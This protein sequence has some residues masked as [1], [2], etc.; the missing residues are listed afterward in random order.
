[1]SIE[2]SKIVNL[3]DAQ[4]LYN[5][6]RGRIKG[7]I[8]DTKGIGDTDFVW[9][10]DKS[11]KENSNLKSAVGTITGNE[12]IEE[13]SENHLYIKNNG[14]TVTIDTPTTTQS[15]VHYMVIECEEGDAFNITASGGDGSRV[16]SFVDV[17]GNNLAMAGKNATYTNRTV[18][19]PADTAYIVV[20]DTTLNGK[21]L[22]NEL[23][24]RV[25]KDTVSK[26]SAFD[27]RF[28]YLFKF[29]NY[30]YEKSGD[31]A[32][33][34]SA[35]D[36][37]QLGIKRD[38]VEFI[39]DGSYINADTEIASIRLSGPVSR[40]TRSSWDIGYF[41]PVIGHEYRLYCIY[42]SGDVS[43][44]ET[45]PSKAPSIGVYKPSASGSYAT[46]IYSDEQ[47]RVYKFTATQTDYNIGMN[48]SLAAQYSFANAK[49][50]LLVQDMTENGIIK[51]L[52]ELEYL[53]KI[54]HVQ[55]DIAKGYWRK[56]GDINPDTTGIC[57]SALIQSTPGDTIKVMINDPKFVYSVMQGDTATSLKFSDR[58]VKYAEFTITGNYWGIIFYK[59][60]D[61]GDGYVN[62]TV[63][64]WDN[65]VILF[66]SDYAVSRESEMHDI[67]EN[68]GVLNV[69]NRAYQMAKLTYNPIANLPTQVDTDKYPHYV[70]T[71]TKV[72]GVMYSSVR[73]EG[74]YVP[75]CVSLDTYMTAL[76]NPN[77]YIYT[78]TEP[79]PHYNA[80]TYYGSV[81]SACVAWCYGIDD[82]IPTTASFAT[83]DGMEVIE[84]QSPY[85]LKLGDMLNKP[86][87]GTASGHIQI[88]TDIARTNRGVI[89]WIELTEQVNYGSHPMTRS[90]KN[91]PSTIQNMIDNQRYVA[92]RYHYIYK[93]PYTPSPW[94]NLD[95]E[96]DEPTW[97]ENISPRRGD[98][99]NWRPG[100]TIEI[101]I[102]DST[103]YTHVKLF[104][105]DELYSNTAI[106]S[107]ENN[108]IQYQDLTYGSYKVCLTDGSSDSEFVYF[109][110][111]DTHETYTYISGRDLLVE[112]SSANATP[113][114]ISF[115]EPSQSDSDYKAVAG[116]HVFTQA[117]ITAGSATVT[118]PDYLSHTEWLVKVMYKT[119]FGLYSGDF[120]Y[121]IMHN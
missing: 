104:K 60:N 118:A 95:D 34:P 106:S 57:S 101:D 47:K 38:G 69:I 111:I 73:N 119:N 44:A 64:D 13:W 80:L 79:S 11:A 90:T 86:N 72:T 10:A 105:D 54:G 6:L 98:K 71:G 28:N 103:G 40:T 65:Q 63:N 12:F 21:V 83:Y 39:L 48:C 87:T 7:G 115:C 49:F 43:C 81:C 35:T 108:L 112:F 66:H 55:F 33:N 15:N 52:S 94:V 36:M 50:I 113:A 37:T 9:S 27:D 17:N 25:V 5:D 121:V 1:M 51:Q 2:A 19:A 31:V 26:V 20:N 24:G 107:F 85:G 46:M 91:T 30:D 78:R 116:F 110:I 4:V 16:Y 53:K 45:T 84:D 67:P 99:A 41:H 75:Q 59:E 32:P 114:S 18:I 100:E 97:N 61:D 23:I 14:P 8:D 62:L 74:L 58:L 92:M 117:E 102:T 22:R 70:P 29:V 68:I 93:V 3:G 96:S 76:L 77:S 89:K 56:N 82:V 120:E 88:V 42:L 109:D